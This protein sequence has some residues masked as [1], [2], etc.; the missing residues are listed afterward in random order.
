MEEKKYSL[1]GWQNIQVIGR[2]TSD[3]VIAKS[4]N[5]NFY[6]KF[7]VA[8]NEYFAGD[9]KTVFL[10]CISF[11][12]TAEFIAKNFKKGSLIHL[13]DGKITISDWQD[14]NLVNHREWEVIF[15]NARFLP[16]NT[17]NPQKENEL[18]QQK[19]TQ[20]SSTPYPDYNNP[21]F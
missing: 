8:I 16:Y 3:P 7:S 4:Q 19:Q 6:C 9:K 15:N 10:K 1:D 20:Q 18:Q 17:P 5:D 2:L 21:P 12:K 14:S 11:N 13:L